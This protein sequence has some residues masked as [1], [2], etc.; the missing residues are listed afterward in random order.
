MNISEKP[1]NIVQA[2]TGSGKTYSA[3][4]KFLNLARDKH[5]CLIVFPT[6]VLVEENFILIKKLKNEN[7]LYKD[8]SIDILTRD[9]PIPD[10]RLLN[11]FFKG[12]CVILTLHNYLTPRGDFYALSSL[13]YLIR[14]FK[15]KIKIFIDEVHLLFES[16]EKNIPITHGYINCKNQLTVIDSSHKLKTYDGYESYQVSNPTVFFE[17]LP[18]FN[19]SSFTQPKTISTK[20][21]S[22]FIINENDVNKLINLN[23]SSV[24]NSN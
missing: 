23:D 19:I 2:P 8:V 3:M 13:F 18:E 7:I 21:D 1:I 22:L 10:I 6:R 24:N 9:D 14:I 4:E 15:N 12:S 16:C 11:F 17:D 20:D 5:V